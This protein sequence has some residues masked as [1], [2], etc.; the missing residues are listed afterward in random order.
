[1]LLRREHLLPTQRYAQAGVLHSL[2]MALK[3][4]YCMHIKTHSKSLRTSIE[5]FWLVVDTA[6]L[7]QPQLLAYCL[8]TDTCPAQLNRW[9]L[10]CEEANSNDSLINPANISLTTTV[11]ETRYIRQLERALKRAD[12]ML[13]VLEEL[14]MMNR[15]AVSRVKCNGCY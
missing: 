4:N 3:R 15:I 7:S 13:A 14:H 5:K 12:A 8:E 10:A 9:R 6:R 2:K 11:A 1:V